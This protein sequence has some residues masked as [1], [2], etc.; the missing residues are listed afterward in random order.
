MSVIRAAGNE[1]RAASRW[2]RV[3]P[4]LFGIAFGVAGL[5]QAWRAAVPVLGT[6]QAIPEALDLAAAVGSR[7]VR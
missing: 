6:P 5:A 2:P 3:P 1:P 4:N 7:R